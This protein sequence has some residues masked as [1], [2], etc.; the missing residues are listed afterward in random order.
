M[1][2]IDYISRDSIGEGISKHLLAPIYCR[3]VAGTRTEKSLEIHLF[4]PTC[5]NMCFKC[6][7]G[8][9][10]VPLFTLFHMG[11]YDFSCV[12]CMVSH[13]KCVLSHIIITC[14]EG[15]MITWDNMSKQSLAYDTMKMV[16]TRG[17]K[18]MKCISFSSL[19]T[20]NQSLCVAEEVCNDK[21]WVL[22][23]P[24]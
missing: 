5:Y 3:S 21:K 7:F 6:V 14:N 23:V 18:C 2:H 9:L 8:A 1:E 12:I 19:K 22:W 11:L 10:P 4:F 13:V 15:I 20:K 16:F 17:I 24:S